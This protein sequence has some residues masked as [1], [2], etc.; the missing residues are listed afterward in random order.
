[1]N[2]VIISGRMTSDPELRY[3]ASGTGVAHFTVATN[4]R[5]DESAPLPMERQDYVPV[6]VWDR[7]GTVCGEV[8]SKGTQILIEGRLQTRQWD[9]DRG[10]RHWKTEVV[11]TTVEVLS[12]AARRRQFD[13]ALE[14][15]A[16]KSRA[17]LHRSSR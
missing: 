3:L 1:M 11:A 10:N 15:E 12:S 17:P 4:E 9:D 2:R 6:I 5:R 14:T 16:V 8:L 7:L 13:K